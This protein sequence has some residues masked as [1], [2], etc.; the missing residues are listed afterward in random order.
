MPASS[1]LHDVVPW[2]SGLLQTRKEASRASGLPP[3]SRRA[4]SYDFHQP[5]FLPGD[6]HEQTAR[7]KGTFCSERN[8]RRPLTHQMG[9]R[10]K[11]N[12]MT[13]TCQ[14]RNIQTPQRQEGRTHVPKTE[15][16][17][18]QENII[19]PLDLKKCQRT[20]AQRKWNSHAGSGDTRY[21]SRVGV[22]SG[23]SL[24]PHRDHASASDS[25]PPRGWGARLV[26][27]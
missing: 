23:E 6:E 7:L 8:T 14:R 24:S 25:L 17:P 13:S 10:S 16:A 4:G 5:F 9:P 19:R 12:T 27:L 18:F 1:L 2:F 15:L 20:M 22:C 3:P 26:G 21:L 11:R